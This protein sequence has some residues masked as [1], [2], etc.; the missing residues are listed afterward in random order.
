M[1]SGENNTLPSELSWK[2]TV[3]ERL[4]NYPILGS[5]PEL[6]VVFTQDLGRNLRAQDSSQQ[7][8]ETTPPSR[9]LLQELLRDGRF[10]AAFSMTTKLLSSE[11]EIRN[12]LEIWQCRINLFIRLGAFSEAKLEIDQF[13]QLE[14]LPIQFGQNSTNGGVPFTLLLSVAHL[15]ILCGYNDRAQGKLTK[16]LNQSSEN[17]EYF[18]TRGKEDFAQLWEDRRLK[19]TAMLVN[20]GV[21]Q[22]DFKFAIDALFDYRDRQK[23]PLEVAKIDSTMGKLFLQFGD[24]ATAESLFQKANKLC[25]GVEG[26]LQI[27]KNNALLSIANG[28]Y[29]AAHAAYGE[30][31]QLKP[32]D[33]T[34]INNMAVCALYM[35]R[36][37]EGT[38]Q[39]EAAL[40]ANPNAML[41]ECTVGN[42]C[43]LYRLQ[44][45][46]GENK[47]AKVREMVA[48]Y[49]PE[50]F[51]CQA[52]ESE[53]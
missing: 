28:N 30:A 18:R 35:G 44:S 32:E 2:Q 52:L 11:S 45:I 51:N 23:D 12:A 40:N 13:S 39:I 15:H 6:K 31:L 48:Q 10:R 5:V 43:A 9:E 26:Q 46:V 29:Q 47:K 8:A 20:Y 19:V 16:L 42:I 38:Q 27:L 53:S 34:F 37:A 50:T 3:L 49:C 21:E 17:I 22:N 36:S 4:S 25:H 24:V 33:I 1:D 41:N 7:H 14:D